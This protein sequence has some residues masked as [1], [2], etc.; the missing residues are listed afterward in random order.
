MKKKSSILHQSI[1]FQTNKKKKKTIK[2]REKIDTVF[3]VFSRMTYYEYI[4]GGANYT[5]TRLH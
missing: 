5:Y 4:V 3:E 2:F 1:F